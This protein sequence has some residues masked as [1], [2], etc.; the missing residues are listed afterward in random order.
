VKEAGARPLPFVAKF[1]DADISPIVIAADIRST[2]GIDASA[3]RDSIDYEGFLKTLVS[4]SEELGI[5]VMRSAIV[6]HATRRTLSVKEFRGFALIDPFAP[7][8]FINDSDAK[9]A[10]IFTFAHELVHIWLGA[11]GIRWR[12]IRLHH[13]FAETLQTLKYCLQAAE[14]YPSQRMDLLV[15]LTQDLRLRKSSSCK[16]SQCKPQLSECLPSK[17]WVE[18]KE[19]GFRPRSR[20]CRSC[21]S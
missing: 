11:A 4:K 19:L 20:I 7:V 13:R 1:A 17:Y 21:G 6:G 5:L 18:C 10:Q 2:L 15:F 3:R 9:A 8:I 14:N 12:Q 16:V